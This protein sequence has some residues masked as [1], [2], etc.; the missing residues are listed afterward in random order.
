MIL[1]YVKTA[2]YEV[3]IKKA[4]MDDWVDF[5][6]PESQI[7]NPVS[8]KCWLDLAHLRIRWKVQCSAKAWRNMIEKRLDNFEA[9]KYKEKML[10]G[11]VG[12]QTQTSS[13][14]PTDPNM[15][16]VVVGPNLYFR[17]DGSPD[18]DP[19]HYWGNGTLSSKIGA[20]VLLRPLNIFPNESLSLERLVEAYMPGRN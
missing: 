2:G 9:T 10:V 7:Y 8:F 6:I 14:Y 18:P 16:R 11:K 13:K 3:K 19:L 20:P 17:A 1:T 4:E 15:R 12:V 5:F